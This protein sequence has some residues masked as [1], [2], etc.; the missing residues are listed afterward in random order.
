MAAER[1]RR[2]YH[3]RSPIGNVHVSL[4]DWFFRHASVHD[5]P[6]DRQ[7][8]S[9]TARQAPK[10]ARRRPKRAPRQ[11]WAPARRPERPPRGP[12]ASRG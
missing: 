7:E 5:G 10:M 11:A 8:H 12:Q 1:A 3:V 6:R 9:N 4:T 2:V